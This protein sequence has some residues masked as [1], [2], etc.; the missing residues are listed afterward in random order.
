MTDN[1]NNAYVYDPDCHIC[2]MLAAEELD[3]SFPEYRV[4]VRCARET[5]WASN[6]KRF[7]TKAE[8]T[9]YLYD[10]RGRWFAPTH[11]RVVDSTVP[12][13]SPF[14]PDEEGLIQ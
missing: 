8:A 10:L 2:R 13:R 9:E 6:G 5:V 14:N 7:E 1:I 12:E 11:F 3:N 4:E